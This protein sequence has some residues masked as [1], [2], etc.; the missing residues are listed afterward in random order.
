MARASSRKFGAGQQDQGKGDGSGGM[1][2][3][4]AETLPENAVLSNRDTARHS[5][6][7]GHDGAHVQTGQYHDHPGNPEG[8]EAEDLPDERPEEGAGERPGEA[9]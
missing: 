2:P 3:D 8:T 4:T 6:Q 5:R 1:G 9:D 7:R